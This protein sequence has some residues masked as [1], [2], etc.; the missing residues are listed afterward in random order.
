MT[1]ETAAL[2]HGTQGIFLMAQIVL[3]HVERRALTAWPRPRQRKPAQVLAERL[4]LEVACAEDG[5]GS[6]RN[7]AVFPVREI[8]LYL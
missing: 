2:G 1:P 4:R 5:A 7:A 3:S 6:S 8:W